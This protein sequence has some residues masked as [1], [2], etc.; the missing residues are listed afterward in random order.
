MKTSLLFYNY[1]FLFL[2]K[3]KGVKDYGNKE[4]RED[5]EGRPFFSL[6]AQVSLVGATSLRRALTS[7]TSP[8]RTSFVFSF[9]FIK[10]F[11][12][13]RILRVQSSKLFNLF[14]F[15]FFFQPFIGLGQAFQGLLQ[16]LFWRKG[17]KRYTRY[18]ICTSYWFSFSGGERGE[19][20]KGNTA[21]TLVLSIGIFLGLPG[22]DILQGEFPSF[23]SR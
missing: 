4:G 5:K 16:V 22:P 19:K 21:L 1:F 14:L 20:E 13:A 3:I 15:I 7:S 8:I 2:I 10:G 6:S 18:T 11:S 17:R 12:P 9:S 23:Y